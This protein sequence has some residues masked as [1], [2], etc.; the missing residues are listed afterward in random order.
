MKRARSA[1]LFVF[2]SLTRELGFE[3]VGFGGRGLS[4][5]NK[6]TERGKIPQ[7]NRN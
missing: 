4:I 2:L 6:K 1:G 5:L 7:N 3:N